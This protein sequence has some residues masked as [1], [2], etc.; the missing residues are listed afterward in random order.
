VVMVG[1]NIGAGH[2]ERAKKIAWT[3]T[4]AGALVCLVIGWSVAVYP[5]LWLHL[6]SDD[7]AVIEIGSLYMRVV[8]PFYP[9]FGAG[10]ALYFASQ[11]AGQMLKPVLAGTA[12]L[13][14]VVVGG[15]LVIQFG[16]PLWALFAVVALGLSVLGGLTAYFVYRARW[17]RA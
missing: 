10:L 11:G 3:G 15:M 13:V 7:D 2:S 8:A 6:F 4:G 17:T 1:T 14:L 12:R 5:P 16:G 9:L